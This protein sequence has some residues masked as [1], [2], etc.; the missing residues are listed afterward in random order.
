MRIMMK[1]LDGKAAGV[2]VACRGN[3]FRGSGIQTAALCEK[4]TV[5]QI[6]SSE[7][8]AHVARRFSDMCDGV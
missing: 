4:S 5:A 7:P 6:D 2:N 3:E 1:L 8:L